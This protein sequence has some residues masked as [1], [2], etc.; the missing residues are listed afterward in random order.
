MSKEGT[1]SLSFPC[2]FSFKVIGKAA[3]EF[4]GE[5]LR[6]FRQH[7]PQ[8]GEGAIRLAHSKKEKYIAYTVTVQAVSQAQLDAAYLDL[9]QH[10]LVLFAL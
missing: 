4:E 3:P 1:S 5:V 7:F 9:S 10:P 6:I 2:Q 8:L